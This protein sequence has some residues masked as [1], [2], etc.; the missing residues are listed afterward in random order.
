MNDGILKKK[1][2]DLEVEKAKAEKANKEKIQ[3]VNR[4]REKL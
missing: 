1:I 4:R 3:D 2:K